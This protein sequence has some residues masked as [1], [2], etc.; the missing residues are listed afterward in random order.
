MKIS[1]SLGI[2]V[3]ALERDEE[4][5]ALV[6][7][8]APPLRD[9]SERPP[10]KLVLVLDRSGSMTGDRL[11]EAKKALCVLV[12][13]LRISDTFGLVTFDHTVDVPVPA[14]PLADKAAVV[15]RIRTVVPGGSTD[16]GAGYLRGVQEARR[17]AGAEGATL[18]LVSDGH[19]NCGVTEPDVLADIAHTATRERVTTSALGMGLGYDETLL[20]AIA[21]GGTGN[22]LFAENAD[23]AGA[24]IAGEVHGLLNQ[25]IQAA[26]LTVAMSPHVRAVRLVNE[27]SAAMVE[28]GLQ[29]ELG[30]FYAEETRKL[31]V[32]FDIPGL[33]ALGLAHVA[34]LKLRYV[35]VTTLQEQVVE[36]PLHVNVVPGDEAAGRIAN[37]V[38]VTELAFQQAQQAKRDAARRLTEGDAVAACADLHRA[39]E[40]VSRAMVGAPSAVAAELRD[41]VKLLQVMAAEAEYGST[42]RAA[43]AMSMDVSYKSRNRGRERPTG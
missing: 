40:F 17:V 32:T 20:S 31:L 22:E 25:S 19:A 15:D 23:T 14:G 18:L 8:T 26:S 10:T 43:K 11:E 28:G 13:R 7:L 29:V 2:D 9:P 41:E 35:D 1:A 6:E 42:S 34:T 24:A 37:P 4:V 3:V 30:G 27:L 38:V 33:S 12:Q 5:S 16:L 21:K 39:Q 36:V